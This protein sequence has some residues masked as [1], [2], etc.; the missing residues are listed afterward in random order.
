MIKTI[1]NSQKTLR[2]KEHIIKSVVFCLLLLFL[3]GCRF[4]P[5]NELSNLNNQNLPKLSIENFFSGNLIAKGVI[6]DYRGTVIRRFKATLDGTWQQNTLS[7]KE[8]WYWDDGDIQPRDWRWVKTSDHSWL[9]YADDVNGAAIGLVSGNI[10]QWQYR[11]VVQSNQFGAIELTMKDVMYL[12]DDNS[13][14]NL[15]DMYKFGLPVGQVIIHID[16]ADHQLKDES[17]DPTFKL[18]Q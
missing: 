6:K 16:R 12:I 15:I 2:R 18:P 9:G 14:I 5:N 7:L 10:T 8:I 1:L 3:G 11:M 13:M 4:F 17:F